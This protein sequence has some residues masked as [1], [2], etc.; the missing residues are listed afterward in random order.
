MQL[1]VQIMH[2]M[3][4]THHYMLGPFKLL[5]QVSLGILHSTDRGV[6]HG[7]PQSAKLSQQGRCSENHQEILTPTGAAIGTI[8]MYTFVRQDH[9]G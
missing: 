3:L 1:V 7:T 6:V 5:A 8:N 9:N 4:K 2:L